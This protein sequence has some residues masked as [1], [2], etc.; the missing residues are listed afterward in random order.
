MNKTIIIL[1]FITQ[2]YLFASLDTAKE[3]IY[4]VKHDQNNAK[5]SYHIYELIELERKLDDLKNQIE[6]V[7]K[8]ELK[9]VDTYEASVLNLQK[10]VDMNQKS[11][12]DH[13]TNLYWVVIGAS[14]FVVAIAFITGI[15]Y[16]D[17]LQDARQMVTQYIGEEKTRHKELRES[18]TSVQTTKLLELE[19][20]V[21]THI[22]DMLKTIKSTKQLKSKIKHDTQSFTNQAGK[23]QQAHEELTSTL[24]AEVQQEFLK[25]LS[26]EEGCEK[27][28]KLISA[29][30]QCACVEKEPAIPKIKSEQSDN[31]PEFA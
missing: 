9:N 21:N 10:A 31:T 16:K 29:F 7:K 22:D 15:K 17:E 24:Q 19:K 13:I 12:Y 4:I 3:N 28:Q 14:V 23:F 18:I 26:T 25:L 5:Q 8:T 1:L 11:F 6:H 30:I 20:N 2:S 27:L